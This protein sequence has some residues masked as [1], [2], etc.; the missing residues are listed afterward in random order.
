MSWL[1]L[2]TVFCQGVTDALTLNT[3]TGAGTMNAI[4]TG[5][6][7]GMVTSTFLVL[8]FSPL[9]YVLIYR[10]FGKARLPSL[11]VESAATAPAAGE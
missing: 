3:G 6:G 9:F 2:G 1:F 5:V 10:A 11:S 7:G 8:L 4:G